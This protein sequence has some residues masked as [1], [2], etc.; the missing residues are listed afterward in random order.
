[1]VLR[2]QGRCA[3]MTEVTGRRAWSERG[4]VSPFLAVAAVGLLTAIGLAYD[5]GGIQI[6]AQQQANAYAA[7]AA[8]AGGQAIN[9][10]PAIATGTVT[11]NRAAAIRAARS[12]LDAAGITG[13]VRFANPTTLTVETTVT[14][15]T[16]FL[17]MIGIDDV[18][19]TGH[20]TARLRRGTITGEPP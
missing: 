15:P 10:G 5:V 3:R 20:A 7:E 2:A 19:A 9:A 11:V 16:A 17:S 8:R 12:Y 14:R 4:S 1:M 6:A 18:S 13:R